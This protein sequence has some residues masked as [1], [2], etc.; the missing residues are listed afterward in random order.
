MAFTVFFRK[1]LGICFFFFNEMVKILSRSI[2]VYL[3]PIVCAA[4]RHFLKTGPSP[5]ALLIE[6]LLKS[7]TCCT[8][9][10]HF[11]FCIRRQAALYQRAF[12][13][14]PLVI[15]LTYCR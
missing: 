13:W 1:I 4:S 14:A 2:Y 9:Y 7:T 8:Y 3:V 12:D 10:I 6:V 5:R 15:E 11:F